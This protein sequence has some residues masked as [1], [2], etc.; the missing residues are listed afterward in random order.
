MCKENKHLKDPYGTGETRWERFCEYWLEGALFPLNEIVVPSLPVYDENDTRIEVED[1]RTKEADEAF[2]D[3]CFEKVKELV[4]PE[5]REIQ[6]VGSLAGGRK[7]MSSHLMNAMSMFGRAEEK[8]DGKI[9]RHADELVHVLYD[10][11]NDAFFFPGDGSKGNP[12]YLTLVN[13]NYPRLQALIGGHPAAH[14]LLNHKT[15]I[16][17]RYRAFIDVLSKG[18]G[19]NPDEQERELIDVLRTW[20]EL[21]LHITIDRDSSNCVVQFVEQPDSADE[22]REIFFQSELPAIETIQLLI[23]LACTED[24]VIC[25][26]KMINNEPEVR[27]EELKKGEKVIYTEAP[28]VYRVRRWLYRHVLNGYLQVE[29]DFARQFSDDKIEEMFRFSSEQAYNNALSVNKKKQLFL[30]IAGHKLS[31]R[32]SYVRNQLFDYASFPE[33]KYEARTFLETRLHWQSYSTELDGW[34][35]SHELPE[36]RISIKNSDGRFTEADWDQ[37]FSRYFPTRLIIDSID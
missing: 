3:L 12:E 21:A 6:L 11:D 31:G 4:G 10:E 14:I 32:I 26:S 15:R 22:D 8:I 37:H 23:M 25:R 9:T 13:V 18:Y 33:K 2:A 29:D 28:Y 1:I 35:W 34:K 19:M 20:N 16:Q 27:K 7:T 24:G 5:Y 17:N 36:I 30:F